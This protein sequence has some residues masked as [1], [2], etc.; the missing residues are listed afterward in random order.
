MAMELLNING[1]K[2]ICTDSG[3]KAL[4]I[5][6]AEKDNI[7]IV[8]LDMIMPD[9]DGNDLFHS[10][11]KLNPA[12]KAILCS[13]YSVDDKAREVIADGIDGYL[14][15]PFESKDLLRVLSQVLMD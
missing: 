15:K 13:G 10:I 11:K 7:D 5:Y 2:T 6:R 8:L 3:A 9:M 4:E 12:V 14:Q 1:F